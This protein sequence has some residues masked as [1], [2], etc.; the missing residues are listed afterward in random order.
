[1]I[2]THDREVA[3]NRRKCAFFDILDPGPIDP[4]RD[5]VLC[6]ACNRARMATDTLSV[7]DDETISHQEL[8]PQKSGTEFTLAREI[9]EPFFS[10]RFSLK[11]DCKCNPRD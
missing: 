7:V 10:F 8:I 1:M 6:L 3:S 4:N 5:F 9:W 11:L 2:A